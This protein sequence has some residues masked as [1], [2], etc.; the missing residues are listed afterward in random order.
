MDGLG[1]LKTD[2]GK[3]RESVN[4]VEL[5]IKEIT[6]RIEAAPLLTEAIEKLR[7][8]ASELDA[9]CERLYNSNHTGKLV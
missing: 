9:G 6:T 1:E 7:N 3:T 4:E 8:K 5:Q 2:L